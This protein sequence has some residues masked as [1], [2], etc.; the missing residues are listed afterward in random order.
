MERIFQDLFEAWLQKMD[1]LMH[2]VEEKCCFGKGWSGVLKELNICAGDIVAIKM[3]QELPEIVLLYIFTKKEVEAVKTEGRETEKQ[4]LGVEHIVINGI[5]WDVRYDAKLRIIYGLK[6]LIKYFGLVENDMILFSFDVNGEFCG[7]IFMCERKKS[8]RSTAESNM[9]RRPSGKFFLFEDN[10][11]DSPVE[12]GLYLSQSNFNFKEYCGIP[13]AVSA[14]NYVAD[15]IQTI[16][17]HLTYKVKRKRDIAEPI[18]KPV[19]NQSSEQ[20]FVSTLPCPS[21]APTH[22]ILALDCEM[23]KSCEP[24]TGKESKEKDT[25]VAQKAMAE[26]MEELRSKEYF[27]YH[28]EFV[29][30]IG[31]D[32]IKPLY[33]VGIMLRTNIF[34][35]EFVTAL[36]FER[37]HDLEFDKDPGRNSSQLLYPSRNISSRNV[38]LDFIINPGRAYGSIPVVWSKSI[39]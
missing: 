1:V 12:I 26:Q 33:V 37:I 24:E 18:R 14:L 21:G 4:L 31:F 30:A 39:D 10:A 17:A 7:R 19:P 9:R 11:T 6:Q 35:L 25:S 22:E 2:W 3:A 36:D 20:V 29:F 28:F 32:V 8:T 15:G 13:R 5:L 34:G 23:G 38:D 16:D 27:T